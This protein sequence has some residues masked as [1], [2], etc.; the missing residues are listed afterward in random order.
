MD[1]ISFAGT[2]QSVERAL[3][4]LRGDPKRRSL[5]GLPLP[6]DTALRTHRI[7]SGGLGA[8]GA[9][10]TMAA[11]NI[12]AFLDF[13]RTAAADEHLQRSRM[14][15][16]AATAAAECCIVFGRADGSAH[17]GAAGSADGEADGMDCDADG[18]TDCGG[19]RSADGEVDRGVDRSADGGV[20]RGVDGGVT[21]A[22]DEG[23][24]DDGAMD[25]EME[26]DGEGEAADETSQSRSEAAD[27][28]SQAGS[29]IGEPLQEEEPTWQK[30]EQM[31]RGTES[32]AGQASESVATAEAELTDADVL[33][34]MMGAAVTAAAIQL[35]L[36]N[37]AA[38]TS[39]GTVIASIDL[40]PSGTLSLFA[41]QLVQTDACPLP[42]VNVLS[43][44]LEHGST[45]H[46]QLHSAMRHTFCIADEKQ[47][48][49]FYDQLQ[50]AWSALDTERLQYAE[51]LHTHTK[52]AALAAAN[53][54]LP[55]FVP[56]AI[57]CML[58][59]DE[60]D[61]D[62][63][64][65]TDKN[66]NWY[67][68]AD[69]HIIGRDDPRPL[70]QQ[71]ARL[72]KGLDALVLEPAATDRCVLVDAFAVVAE[73]LPKLREDVA[74]AE[75]A[76]AKRVAI[77]DR[78]NAQRQAAKE[79]KAEKPPKEKAPKEKK[80]P[81][82]AKVAK[83][84]GSTQVMKRQHERTPSVPPPRLCPRNIGCHAE[85]LHRACP[86]Q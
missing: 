15:E 29:A 67:G 46:C 24:L 48:L 64:L 43:L 72:M 30:M 1:C 28:S 66:Y 33:A 68:D 20:D 49:S 70:Q 51:S 60:C 81:A 2:K 23:D 50:T 22:T 57:L 39:A 79:G 62:S 13:Q 44:D 17:V 25:A 16:R 27:D 40:S 10:G 59:F 76:Y 6:S 18:D 58:G 21:R 61:L 75:L 63:A 31:M 71:Y 36:A 69:L 78:K 3:A 7:A 41:S 53:R 73:H 83:A 37:D 45:L 26:I 74:K 55:P 35:A 54:S 42:L 82:K 8:G 5:M 34:E 11:K 4:V 85:S 9:V 52:E 38:A 32:E 65:E 19:D 77:Y 14:L 80:A 84:S 12:H 47:A 56:S 86:R